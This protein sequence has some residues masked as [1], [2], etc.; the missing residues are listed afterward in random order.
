MT[1]R[2]NKSNDAAIGLRI[3]VARMAAGLSQ[4][5]LATALDLTFQQ[6]QK[7]EKG[8]NRVGA[9]QIQTIARLLNTSVGAIVGEADD[10]TPDERQIS[11]LHFLATRQGSRIML[12][13]NRLKTRRQ[14]DAI[15]QMI[16]VMANVP[17]EKNHVVL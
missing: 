11:A 2:S 15:L 10:Q 3:K 6:I 17:E 14:R 9:G 16:E 1:R 12:A 5:K 7:Y 13:F 4:E 8:A